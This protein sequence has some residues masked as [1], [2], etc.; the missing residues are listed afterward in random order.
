MKKT[1]AKGQRA[2]FL[3][4]EPNNLPH[5]SDESSPQVETFQRKPADEL[6]KVTDFIKLRKAP[7]TARSSRDADG[8]E[9]VFS[10]EP[11]IAYKYDPGL[12]RHEDVMLT[13]KTT[14]Q[15]EKNDRQAE[16]MNR[17]SADVFGREAARPYVLG[18][19]A[20]FSL[21]HD[22]FDW[23]LGGVEMGFFRG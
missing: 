17:T 16:H 4:N 13:V 12:G 3:P 2:R 10:S 7:K 21:A 8:A 19:V 6:E 15:L 5:H 18:L 20:A 9:P 11:L 22:R 23:S 1:A 14:L